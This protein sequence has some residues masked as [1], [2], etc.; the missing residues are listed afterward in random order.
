[1]INQRQSTYP[2]REP[3]Q[4]IRATSVDGFFSWAEDTLRRISGEGTLADERMLVIVDD[5]VL[6]GALSRA[7]AT[8]AGVPRDRVST[9]VGARSAEV[10]VRPTSGFGVD[11]DDVGAAAQRELER[12]APRPPVRQ[13][14][15]VEA[16]GVI[17]R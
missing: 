1:M 17:E 3:A 5:E 14:V 16:A 4:T 15:R 6:A 13:R 10:T 8:V 12:L 7:A 9:S 11:R 2:S